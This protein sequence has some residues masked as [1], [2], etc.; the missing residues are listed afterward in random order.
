[1][2]K[3]IKEKWLAAL[4][5]GEYKKGTSALQGHPGYFCC[6][7]VLCDLYAKETGVGKWSPQSWHLS[8][9]LPNNSTSDACL[10]R[11]VADWAEL[12]EIDPLVGARPISFFNDCGENCYEDFSDVIPLIEEY[13]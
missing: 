12:R 8:F 5:S 9:I 11:E 7:G 2:V 3:E 1:M 13:L 6:L 10:P 4:R